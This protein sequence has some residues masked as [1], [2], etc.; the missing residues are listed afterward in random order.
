M[1]EEEKYTN[2]PFSV[3]L[4]FYTHKSSEALMKKNGFKIG[5]N[6]FHLLND[7]EKYV[8]RVS[9]INGDLRRVF[10]Q[11]NSIRVF[12]RRFP[13]KK[14]YYENGIGELDYI[15]YHTESLVHKIHTIMEI[16]KLMVNEVYCLGIQERNCNWKNLTRK[17]DKETDCLRVIDNYLDVFKDYIDLRHINTHRGIYKDGEK[18][19]IEMDFGLD[20]YL[21]SQSLGYELDEK[22]QKAFPKFMIDYKIKELKKQRIEFINKTEKIINEKLKLFLS[23]LSEEFNNRTKTFYNTV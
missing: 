3:T 6:N 22:F 19:E 12:I 18:E 13:N 23:A 14:F 4:L 8:S 1:T 2:N 7:T 20:I 15:Q 5:Q 9:K 16:M 21:M 10:E 11:L 17:L